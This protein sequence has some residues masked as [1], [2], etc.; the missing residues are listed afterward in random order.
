MKRPIILLTSLLLAG[1]LTA[2]SPS[3]NQG[4]SHRITFDNTGMVAHALGK[5]D[6]HIGSDGSLAIGN[7]TV[8][9]TP[10]QRVLLQQYYQ[11]ADA[12]IETGKQLRVAGA[13]L[14]KNVIG[15]LI[16]SILHGDSATAEKQMEAQSNG[17][18]A[19]A[20][21]LCTNLKAMNATQKEIAAQIPAFAP[22][23][24]SDS[25][26]HCDV[27]HRTV[28]RHSDGT[29]TTTTT[30]SVPDKR[31]SDSTTTHTTIQ[32]PTS[33]AAASSTDKREHP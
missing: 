22:Y 9:V 28:V 24:L 29:T 18:Q 23:A 27:T 21:G 12:T 14:G 17:I 5:P 7:R 15:N 32:I 33:A 8:A 26:M 11:Q 10:P 6:A 30:T 19:A 1:V 16:H 2:C 25:D 4:L 20:T 31:G 13:K 3:I